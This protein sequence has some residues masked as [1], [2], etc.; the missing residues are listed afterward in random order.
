MICLYGRSFD[1]LSEIKKRN[2]SEENRTHF[3]LNLSFF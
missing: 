1:A 3:D 2:F